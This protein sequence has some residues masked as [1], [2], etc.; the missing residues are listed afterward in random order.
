MSSFFMCFFCKK[1]IISHCKYITKYKN[2]NRME[3]N[4]IKICSYDQATKI[5]GYSVFNNKELVTFGKLEV[6]EELNYIK[7]IKLMSELI[8]QSIILHK[9]EIVLFEDTQYQNNVLTLKQLC[10]LQGSIINILHEFE[11]K[12]FI[13]EP[14]KWRSGLGIKGRK[15][16]EQKFNTQLKV[17]ELYGIEVSEDEADAI[18]LASFYLQREE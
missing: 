18:A 15:R 8:K 2:V 13:I 5:T 17:K 7:R 1:S 11:L 9:P 6:N 4:K 12:F 14:T 16:K 3:E 10:Q